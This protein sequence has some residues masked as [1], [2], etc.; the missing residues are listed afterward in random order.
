[1]G[2]LLLG[3]MPLAQASV[4][5]DVFGNEDK[6]WVEV[7]PA[8]PAPPEDGDLIPFFVSSASS[9]RFAIDQKSLSI[10]T[11]GVVHYTLVA[12][13]KEGARNVSFEGIRCHT[14]E[15]K[16]YAYG[17]GNGSFTERI[18]PTWKHIDEAV[19]NRDR[20]A[21]LKD[22]LCPNGVPLRVAEIV[23]R[24]K[25]RPYKSIPQ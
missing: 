3:A 5:D 14:R 18:D 13:S 10:G 15:Y 22:Y 21:L 8:I 23:E 24:L 17:E 11:D 16:V 6:N 9:F 25:Q 1:L 4:F 20:A 7:P 19:A 12:T 2:L